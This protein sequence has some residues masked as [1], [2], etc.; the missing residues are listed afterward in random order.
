ML[1][2][3]V[4]AMTLWVK[5]RDTASKMSQGW[6]SQLPRTGNNLVGWNAQLTYP[7][8]PNDKLRWHPAIIIEAIAS[9]DGKPENSTYIAF[10]ITDSETE[11]LPP[12][13]PAPG[14]LIAKATSQATFKHFG[15]TSKGPLAN[16]QQ[17]AH[18]KRLAAQTTA[19]DD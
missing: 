9:A 18:A 11:P 10:V 1:A 8:G 16:A 3:S 17:L 4:A 7:S 14:A 15:L 13:F 6:Q 12:P 5:Q 2:L 19:E